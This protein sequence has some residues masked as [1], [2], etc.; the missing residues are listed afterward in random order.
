MIQMLKTYTFKNSEKP[1]E[2]GL[3]SK[4]TITLCIEPNATE[5][6]MLETKLNL[7]Q[8]MINDALDM[9]ETPRIE[10][11]DNQTFFYV[12]YCNPNNNEL[13]TEPITIIDTKKQLVL[14][15]R[16]KSSFSDK[17]LGKLTG[18]SSQRTR[19]IL[20]I[21]SEINQAYRTYLLKVSKEVLSVRSK[22]NKHDI[23]NKDFIKFIDI[24]EDLN[25]I[26]G[27]LQSCNQLMTTLLRGKVLKMYEDDVDL[28]EDVEL[29]IKELLT[30]AETRKLTIASTREAYSTIMANNLNKTFKKLTSISI[31]M[32][33][34]TITSGLYGMNLVLPLA[35][36]HFA[37]WYIL[38]IVMLITGLVI[39][40]F[41]KLKWL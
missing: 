31:F 12:R 15:F 33:I 9:Y 6:K 1:L 41:K 34:P 35:K 2:A 16:L 21:M 23:D 18:H 17:I 13:A 11:Y 5:I 28:A 24:E 14:I 8:D 26:I 19:L 38:A 32:T 36:N 10:Q 25:E 4:D 22:L 29:G 30:V 39:W 27:T 37:F 3:G 40:L 20:T 7:E